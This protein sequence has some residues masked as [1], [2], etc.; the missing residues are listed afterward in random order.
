M[1][2]S[3]SEIYLDKLNKS[4]NPIKVL[5]EFYKAIFELDNIDSNLYKIFA[6]LYKIYGKEIL[7]F[8][9]L[10]C[11]DIEEINFSSITR[12]ISYFAKKRLQAKY[13]YSSMNYLDPLASKV[14]S[15]LSKKRRIKI[16]QPFEEVVSE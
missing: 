12:L 11:S 15:E 5:V 9:I 1:E 7:F 10:D 13:D 14:L 3:L 6:R 16:P 8:S 4:E 2:E